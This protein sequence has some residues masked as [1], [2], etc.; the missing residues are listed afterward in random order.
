MSLSLR[1]VFNVRLYCALNG[2]HEISDRS[3]FLSE[4]TT[5]KEEMMRNSQASIA[6]RFGKENC[7]CT[8]CF[9]AL[10]DVLS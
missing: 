2:K 7:F 4:R 1:L 6:V 10:R 8:V 9:S 3:K 5:R